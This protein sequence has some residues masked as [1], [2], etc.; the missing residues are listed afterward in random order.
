MPLVP[1]VCEN[2]ACSATERH[3]GRIIYASGKEGRLHNHCCVCVLETHPMM[4]EYR[5]HYNTLCEL[6]REM[7]VLYDIMETTLNFFNSIYTMLNADI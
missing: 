5:S 7:R 6:Q 1:F 4:G 2:E 3:K